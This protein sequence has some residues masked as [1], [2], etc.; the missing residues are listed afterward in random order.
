MTPTLSPDLASLFA[1]TALGHVTREYPHKAD[2]VMVSDA[3]AYIPREV[4]PIFYGSFDWH[5]CVHGY[6][7]LARLRRLFPDI[8]EASAIDA[9]FA[10]S[11]TPDKVAVECDYAGRPSARGFERPY[12][13]AWLLMLAAELRWSHSPYAATLQ[14][15]ADH[16][17]AAFGRYLPLLTYAVRAGTHNNTAFALVLAARYAEAVEDPGLR[18]LLAERARHWFGGDQAVQALEPSGEDFLSPLLIE[19]L[20]MHTL[21]TAEEFVEWLSRFLPRLA[22]RTPAALFIPAEVSDRSDGKFAHLDGL[23][24]SR[25]WAMRAIA[26]GLADGEAREQLLASADDHLNA[27]M[28]H[29]VGDYMGEHWLASFALLAMETFASPKQPLPDIP[30]R[31]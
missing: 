26:A 21:L 28:D 16:F 12:G 5:S 4:H 22:A 13:W 1:R 23:N 19:A 11:F 20:A 25:A 18:S 17:A 2:H 14:P 31:R 27:A 24:L 3:D 6:W 7:L 8:P 15:L 9:L 29:V 30:R 10:S